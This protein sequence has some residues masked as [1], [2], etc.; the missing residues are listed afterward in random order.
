[1]SNWS[2]YQHTQGPGKK[3]RKEKKAWETNS[4]NYRDHCYKGLRSYASNASHASKPSNASKSSASMSRLPSYFC[5]FKGLSRELTAWIPFISSNIIP[6]KYSIMIKFELNC[7]KITRLYRVYCW[8][9]WNVVSLSSFP[10][11]R[12]LQRVRTRDFTRL[13]TGA[14]LYLNALFQLKVW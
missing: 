11:L 9:W 13:S 3:S 1:M 2:T 6:H 7:V 14:T 5:W 12:C 8:Q 10:Q 4:S